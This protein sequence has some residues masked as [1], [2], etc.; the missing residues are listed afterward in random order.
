MNKTPPISLPS[1]SDHKITLPKFVLIDL[2]PKTT[3]SPLAF[4]RISPPEP[5]KEVSSELFISISPP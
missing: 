2:L 1:L 4:K 5:P 3:I